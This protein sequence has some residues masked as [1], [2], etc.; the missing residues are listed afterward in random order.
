MSQDERLG[1]IGARVESIQSELSEVKEMH[2][3]HC[4]KEDRD[5][6]K[7]LDKLDTIE[8]RQND[9]I[10]ELTV[11]K[12]VAKG[13]LVTLGGLITFLAGDIVKALKGIF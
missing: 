4:E 9:T 3:D 10:T 2:K 1:Y 8:S 13:A 5:R 12:R 11:Y 6:D 7:I